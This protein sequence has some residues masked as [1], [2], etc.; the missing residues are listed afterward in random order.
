[1]EIK[2][3]ANGIANRIYRKE[4]KVCARNTGKIPYKSDGK[5]WVD[6]SER[7]ICWWTNGFWGGL[8]WQLGA[9]YGDGNMCNAACDTEEK[10]D[11]SFMCARGMDHDSGFKWLLTSGASLRV[12]GNEK[13]RNR[14]FLAA[15]NLAGRFNFVGKFIRAW[16]D[17]GDGS[18]AGWAI[19]DC[20]MN[21]PL[22]YYA[23]ELSN[24][25]RY[26]HIAE[27]HAAT[28]S[29]NFIRSDGSVCHIVE[30]DPLTGKR[31]RNYGGQG[32][33]ENS[34]WTRGQAW[35]VYGFTLC[36]LHS[37][38]ENLLGTAVKAADYFVAHI[39][40]SGLIPVDFLA[41]CGDWEDSSAAAVA[42]CGLIEL[43]RITQN[44]KYMNAAVRLLTA[45]TENRCDFSE[46][47]DCIVNGC[48]VAYHGDE[49]NIPLVYADYFFTE[50]VLKLCGKETFLW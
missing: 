49:H 38:N 31:L 47:T 16:N 23:S 5:R 14:I 45:L 18:K 3:W 21:L 22:L 2:E 36:Y 33:D 20:M 10:L 40:Q 6:I 11:A 42:A 50:A 13:S 8:M 1:M 7:D 28:A 24:D 17:D 43:Y 30:F 48:S 39:P 44:D 46:D 41:D 35:A 37:Q 27:A 26:F 34:C 12:T 29:K 9:A 25:P 15:D 19:I 4:T 32:C